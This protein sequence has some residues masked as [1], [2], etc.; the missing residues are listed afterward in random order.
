[1][2]KK[3]FT[4][5][6]A[7]FV[8]IVFIAAATA[9]AV[10]NYGSQANPLVT[11]SYIDEVASRDILTE[12]DGLI[13]SAEDEL[14]ARFD[15]QMQSF[16][17]GEISVPTTYKTVTLNNNQVVRCTV[18]TE[19]I[20]RSGSATCYGNGPDFLFD[21]TAGTPLTTAGASITNNHLYLVTYAK[22]GFRAR[23][24][25]TVVMISG[26]FTIYDNL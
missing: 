5:G 18:G 2:K 8:G 25:G 7:V 16:S 12:V 3:R 13:K 15:S 6:L 23:A 20:V 22:N 9:I 17:S 1:M 21:T 19:I 24:N 11:R 14:G 26:D 4:I 10:T